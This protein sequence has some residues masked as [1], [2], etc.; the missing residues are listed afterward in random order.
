MN[1]DE[2]L[3]AFRN[4]EQQGFNF[5]YNRFS[6]AIYFFCLR[7][8]GE[9]ETAEDLT[10]SA[11]IKLWEYR[12][13]IKT[14]SGIRSY[15]YSIARNACYDYNKSKGRKEKILE[16]FS[17]IHCEEH[18]PGILQEMMRAEVI[19]QLYT[20]LE[21]LPGQCRKVFTLLYIQ[22]KSYAETARELNIT[23]S[24]VKSHRVKGIAILR[25]KMSYFFLLFF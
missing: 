9:K 6:Q 15:L 21:S 19:N 17:S 16:E 11:F 2:L 3:S 8:T 18:E 12:S 24:T 13:E 7:L 1:E 23:I 10:A 25:K 14:T 5:I 20:A 4:G 22:G